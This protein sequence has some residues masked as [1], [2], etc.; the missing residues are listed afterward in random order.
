MNY[1]KRAMD[2]IRNEEIRVL[3]QI[4]REEDGAEING[5]QK[6]AIRQLKALARRGNSDA[7][8][9]LNRLRRVPDMHPFMREL[10]AA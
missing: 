9:A 10:L 8:R 3:Y 5:P 7:D 2:E 4:A 6:E 1:G